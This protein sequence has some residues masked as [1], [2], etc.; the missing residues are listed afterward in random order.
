MV[1]VGLRVAVIV[2]P[3]HRQKYANTVSSYNL[4][5]FMEL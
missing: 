5:Y 4:I 1:A 3:I 2:I